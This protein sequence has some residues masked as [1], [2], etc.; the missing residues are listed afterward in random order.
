M[1]ERDVVVIGAGNGGLAAAAA[2]Q[3]KGLRTLLLER[4]NI[5]GGAATSFVRGDFEFEV[6][7]HQLSGV[8]TEH[9]PFMLRQFFDE[10]GLSERV[11]LV[12]EHELYRYIVPGHIDITLPADMRGIARVLSE[13]FP[14]ER[15]AIEDYLR[16]CALL[17]MEFYVSLPQV[18]RTN[19]PEDLLRKCPTF[20][21]HGMRSCRAVVNDFFKDETLKAVLLGY[22]GYLGVPGS[23]LPF[24]E[25]AGMF[26]TY[27]EHK[28]WH[29][30]GGSQA[31][32]NALIQAFLEA[33]G[34]VQFN[35]AATRIHT[36]NGVVNGVTTA[37]GEH[38]SCRVVISNASSVHTYNELLDLEE[39]PEQIRQEFRQSR[40][41]VS[42]VI[43]YMGLDCPPEKLGITTAST[44]INTTLDDDAV[45]DQGY[46]LDPPKGALLTSYTSAHQSFSPPGKTNASLM[47][48]QYSAPWEAL[49]TEQY[50][51]AKYRFA[52]ELLALAERV[53][54]GLRDHIEELEIA[55]PLTVMRYLNTPGGAIY[56]FQQTEIQSIPLERKPLAVDGLYLAGAWATIGGFQS[57]YH[58]G[59][60]TARAVARR[61]AKE[62]VA[63]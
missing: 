13:R 49:D 40:P 34:E 43:L 52:Q 26:Y 35:T 62:G 4:H 14:A 53:F 58:S 27:A 15:K 57:A 41:G 16:T 51:A 33:G 50:A 37:N 7:L 29:V 60:F 46:T 22:W 11:T 28:P 56:G 48:L 18:L 8:G 19:V 44:F 54:P 59:Q 3:R 9:N 23:K 2:L 30:I 6:A 17:A 20:A 55:T 38:I 12:E 10:I 45:H 32:S 25:L 61:F 39:T 42:G 1:T 63:A 47:S 24:A 36:T 5:P 21:K 31:I